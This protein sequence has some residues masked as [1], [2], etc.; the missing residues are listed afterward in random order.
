MLNEFLKQCAFVLCRLF[1][2]DGLKLD[3]AA[4]SSNLEEVEDVASSP[5]VTKSFTDDERSEAVMQACGSSIEMQPP[6]DDRFPIKNSDSP[7][8]PV[9]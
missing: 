9:S 2:K 8:F 3:D 4:E 1:K 7:S 6:A 5:T